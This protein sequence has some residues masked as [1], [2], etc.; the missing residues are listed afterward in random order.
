MLNKKGI[1]TTEVAI[2]ATT[3]AMNNLEKLMAISDD[4][5]H[6]KITSISAGLWRQRPGYYQAVTERKGP[7]HWL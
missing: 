7:L 6:R 1:P 2:F 3:T 5:K 4:F